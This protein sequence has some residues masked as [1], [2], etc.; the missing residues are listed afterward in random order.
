M[1]SDSTPTRSMMVLLARLRSAEAVCEA[2]RQLVVDPPY[3][4]CRG[5][6]CLL[7][8]L[9]ADKLGS[10][11]GDD[12]LGFPTQTWAVAEGDRLRDVV[13]RWGRLL[14]ARGELS[15]TEW[16]EG[17]AGPKEGPGA[18]VRVLPPNDLVDEM[19]A[20]EAPHRRLYSSTTQ[21]ERTP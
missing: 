5:P 17:Y 14:I 10:W 13:T 21:E 20:L 2:A 18:H 15:V 4:D 11:S 19:E 7:C 12:D 9:L 16:L 1:T 3:H 8:G 6:M